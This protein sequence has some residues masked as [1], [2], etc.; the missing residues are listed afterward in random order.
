SNLVLLSISLFFSPGSIAAIVSLFIVLVLV[1][2]GGL[3]YYKIG[4][5]NYGRLLD[6]QD[7]GM[8]GNFNNP[9][10]DPYDA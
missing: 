7:Y 3:Y 9:M 6:S 2:L 8:T 5:T 4:R 1:V 10:Y